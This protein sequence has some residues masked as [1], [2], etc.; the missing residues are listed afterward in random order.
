[1]LLIRHLAR[2]VLQLVRFALWGGGR[3]AMVLVLVGAP[4]VVLGQT[5]RHE[6]FGGIA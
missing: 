5:V 6:L 2:V 3:W 1:M 4:V